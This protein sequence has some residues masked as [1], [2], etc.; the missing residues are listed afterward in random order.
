MAKKA[1]KKRAKSKTRAVPLS[2][3]KRKKMSN[4]PKPFPYHAGEARDRSAE[5]ASVIVRE[6]ASAV[7]ETSLLRRLARMLVSANVILRLLEGQGAKTRPGVRKI[8]D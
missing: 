6:A 7:E 3:K 4:K 5:E 2:T 8:E 1:N